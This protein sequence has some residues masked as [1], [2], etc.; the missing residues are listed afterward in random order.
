MAHSSEEALKGDVEE[1]TPAA[2]S[3]A[4]ALADSVEPEP[5]DG[6]SVAA[7]GG[8]MGAWLDGSAHRYSGSRK[9]QIICLY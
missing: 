2:A 1:V 8:A 5:S 4:N 9:L 7:F 6:A 3:P